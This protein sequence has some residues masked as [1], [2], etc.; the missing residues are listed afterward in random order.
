MWEGGGV[1]VLSMSDLFINF[2]ISQCAPDDDVS[3]P[4]MC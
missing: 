1:G 3:W 4:M 2:A